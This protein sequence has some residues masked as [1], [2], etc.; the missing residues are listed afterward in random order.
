M[1]KL[2]DTWVADA[3][4]DERLLASSVAV[5]EFARSSGALHA[6][7]PRRL[8]G[9]ALW[10]WT[11]RGKPARKYRIRY[12]TRAALRRQETLGMSGA[13]KYLAHDHV[14]QRQTVISY[15]L[16]QDTDVRAALLAA[17]ACVVTREEHAQLAQYKHLHG[18]ARYLEAGIVPLDLATHIEVDLVAF[19]AADRTAWGT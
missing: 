15:L 8:V 19:V 3:L 18:W 12:R 4:E 11:E 5:V 1:P 2:I 16:Q 10:F 7:H 13:A 9:E 14:H 17:Q 6:D